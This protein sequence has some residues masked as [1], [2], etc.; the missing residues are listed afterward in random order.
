MEATTV[1]E[2][3]ELWRPNREKPEAQM[4]KALV[5]LVLLI[6]AALLL[7]VTIGGWERL[8]SFGVA[9]MTIIYAAIYIVFAYLIAR[10][11]RGILPVAAAL[12]IILAIFAAVA[13]PGWFARAKEGLDSPALP[14]ELL[15][16]LTLLL[17]P[18]Q[19]VLVA[20]TLIAFN[21]NW[22]VEEERPVGGEPPDEYEPEGPEPTAP[23]PT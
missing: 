19:L 15:G 18:V 22:H 20:I 3:Y 14:E 6:S 21:Q 4:T 8:Q 7:I 2:G 13:A 12:A 9:M 17:V 1:R 16:L 11:Q 23:Q 5:S 10:W